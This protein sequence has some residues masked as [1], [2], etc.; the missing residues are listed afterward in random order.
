MQERDG[1]SSRSVDT[2]LGLILIN[3]PDDTLG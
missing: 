2:S 3:L 1:L